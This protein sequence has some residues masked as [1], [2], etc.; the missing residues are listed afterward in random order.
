MYGWF[1]VKI[2]TKPKT[3]H[4][5]QT[6]QYNG[7]SLAA[8]WS[9][10]GKVHLWDLS[11]PLQAVDEPRVM[12]AYTR[13][14]ES[15]E[16]LFTFSHQIEGYAMDWAQTSP[17]TIVIRMLPLLLFA[18][19][20]QRARPHLSIYP[21]FFKQHLLLNHI[22]NCIQTLQKSSFCD[23]LLL[24]FKKNKFHIKLWLPWQLI[25]FFKRSFKYWPLHVI[26]FILHRLI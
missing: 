25:G 14:E 19:L 3:S 8:T 5:F 18:H 20:T 17:G 10:K 24:L 13:N 4:F 15:P 21:Y 2:Y 7:K 23:P 16:A 9:D 26:Q 12:S 1:T 6:T 22:A 11:R